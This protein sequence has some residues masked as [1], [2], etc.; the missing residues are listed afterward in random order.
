VTS[1]PA[2]P[3]IDDTR[4]CSNQPV[5]GFRDRWIGFVVDEEQE[6]AANAVTAVQ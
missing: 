2:H 4:K 1:A 6:A 5:H 3:Q